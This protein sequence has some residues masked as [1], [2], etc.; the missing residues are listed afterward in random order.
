MF[1][2]LALYGIPDKIIKAIKTMYTNTKSRVVTHGETEY[3]DIVSGVLQVDTLAP[4]L[5]ILVLDYVLRISMDK[6]YKTI[7]K[8]FCLSQGE[9]PDIQPSTALDF[10]DDLAI[11][12]NTVN[13][14]QS[15]IHALEAAFAYVGLYAIKLKQS[16]YPLKLILK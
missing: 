7:Q 11:T 8:T 13:N 4:F 3:F 2:I 10:A 12:S 1:E 16:F 6:Q 5:F 15:L 9:A 14:A